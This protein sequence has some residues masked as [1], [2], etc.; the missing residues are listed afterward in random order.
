MRGIAFGAVQACD[1]EDAGASLHGVTNDPVHFASTSAAGLQRV[2][3][4]EGC[5]SVSVIEPMMPKVINK[6]YNGADFTGSVFSR[7]FG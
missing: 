7:L 5:G 1:D 4:T 3:D 2:D 6:K